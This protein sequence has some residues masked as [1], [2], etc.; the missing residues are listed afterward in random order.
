MENHEINKKLHILKQLYMIAGDNL[1]EVTI[2][3][4]INEYLS[5]D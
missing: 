5:I 3:R 4:E 2:D 1:S